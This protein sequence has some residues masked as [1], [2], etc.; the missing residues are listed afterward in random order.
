MF[1]LNVNE[2]DTF[3][4]SGDQNLLRETLSQDR[5]QLVSVTALNLEHARAL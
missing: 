3:K 4:R 5:E 1:A 2:Q